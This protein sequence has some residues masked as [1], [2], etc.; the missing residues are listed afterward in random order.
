MS[1]YKDMSKSLRPASRKKLKGVMQHAMKTMKKG[2]TEIT[3]KRRFTSKK[4]KK[5]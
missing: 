4:G 3:V 1:N 5:L 2:F